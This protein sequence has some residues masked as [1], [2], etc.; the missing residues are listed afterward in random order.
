MSKK[1]DALKL[2]LST[3]EGWA[4]HGKW[5]WPESALEQ[6]KR[7][8]TEA[9]TAI[10]EAMAEQPAHVAAINTSS[11]RVENQAQNVH[12]QPAQQQ[13]PVAWMKDCADF[14]EHYTCISEASQENYKA[15]AQM[16]VE[17]LRTSPQPSKP[18]TDE[19]I[20]MAFRKAFPV[21][22]VVFTNGAIDFARF[23][24]AAHGI[25]GSA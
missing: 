12:M 1:D 5:V 11:E 23:I 24:E 10:K 13:E 21:G 19:Q 20:G 25:K 17:K 16:W 18:L 14:W 15:E 3:L 2:A 9:I 22:G 6:A 4:G 8:T 7:N